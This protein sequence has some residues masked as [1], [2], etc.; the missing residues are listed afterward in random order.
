M[1][2]AAE[3][4]EERLDAAA[5]GARWGRGCCRRCRDW[6]RTLPAAWLALERAPLEER[7]VDG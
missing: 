1:S 7:S 4:R 2:A 5:G 3:P 6:R